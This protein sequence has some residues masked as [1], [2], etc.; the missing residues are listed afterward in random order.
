MPTEIPES[1]SDC[2]HENYRMLIRD[3][4]YFCKLL[5]RKYIPQNKLHVNSASAYGCDPKKVRRYLDPS[6]AS[7]RN[8]TEKASGHSGNWLKKCLCRLFGCRP[9]PMPF[10]KETLVGYIIKPYTPVEN[11]PTDRTDINIKQLKFFPVW[12]LEDANGYEEVL[13]HGIVFEYS[14]VSKYQEGGYPCE[15]HVLAEEVAPVLS[16]FD[17][18]TFQYYTEGA[19]NKAFISRHDLFLIANYS[20][21]IGIVGAKISTG[22]YVTHQYADGNSGP[23]T[24]CNVDYFTYRLIGLC[25]KE[26]EEETMA[27]NEIVLVSANSTDCGQDSTLPNRLRTS[28]GNDPN[29]STQTGAHGNPCPPTWRP[30]P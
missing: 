19:F 5:F 29:S 24:D 21:Y 7:E 3:S 6:I 22:N 9:K 10:A 12:L 8:N 1:T 14:Y 13:E 4:D 30:Q 16:E 11:A 17:H 27:A 28:D 20:E 18:N 26:C 2:G 25:G 15:G 23:L